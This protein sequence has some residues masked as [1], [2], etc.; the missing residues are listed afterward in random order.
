MALEK[1][2]RGYKRI[3][4]N[5]DPVMSESPIE[6]YLDLL[7][8]SLTDTLFKVEPDI[9]APELDFTVQ[10]V[11]HYVE[12]PAVSMLPVV[13]FDNLRHCIVDVIRRGVPGDL[14][15]TGVWRGGAAIFMRAVLKA[16]NVTDR[17]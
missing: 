3:E 5:P 7:K 1:L 16:Y 9:T 15:E 14:I 11:R 8:R 17:L 4:M 2:G 13:R 12:G 6:L 10:M